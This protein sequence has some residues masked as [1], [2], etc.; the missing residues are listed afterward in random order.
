VFTKKHST[1]EQSCKSGYCRKKLNEYRELTSKQYDDID[2]LET[3]IKDKD[4]F[5]QTLVKAKNDYQNEVITLKKK[6]SDI[7]KENNDL[8]EKVDQL[9][10][11]TDIGLNLLKNCQE[12]ENKLKKELKEYKANSH[13]TDEIMKQMSKENEN[14]NLKLKFVKDS[15][16]KNMKANQ[17]LQNISDSVDS[18]LKDLEVEHLACKQESVMVEKNNVTAISNFEHRLKEQDVL[19]EVLNAEKNLLKQKHDDVVDELLMRN[20]EIEKLKIENE[21][22]SLQNSTSS[23]SE[24]LDNVNIFG[25]KKC[26]ITFS[27]LKELKQ[28]TKETHAKTLHKKNY[29]MRKLSDLEQN[30]SQQKIDITSSVFKLKNKEMKKRDTCSCRGYCIITHTKHNFVKSRSEELLL[31]I[32]SLNAQIENCTT[33]KSGDHG[34]IRKR[35]TCNQCEKDFFLNKET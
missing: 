15:L 14:L 5:V 9:D 18:K 30:V 4:A 31:K 12:R 10:E 2:T 29:L 7:I 28:H 17:E 6:N 35:Y 32:K 3:D 13:K 19:K 25:C 11:D 26:D 34:A 24:E 21:K 16:E 33:S 20:K 8:L 27:N 1:M 22:K 23:L